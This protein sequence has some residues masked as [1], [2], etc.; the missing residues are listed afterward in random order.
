[1]LN[2]CHADRKKGASA[3]YLLLAI[4]IF[5]GCVSIPSDIEPVQGFELERYLG[6]WYEIARLDHRFERGL[7]NVTAE[8]SIREDGRVRVSIR[9]TGAGIPEDALEHLFVP[10]APQLGE[11]G[12][13]VR[14]VLVERANRH[15]GLSSNAIRRA[16]FR[17]PP[18]DLTARL[19]RLKPPILTDTYAPVERLLFAVTPDQ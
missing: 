13:F 17:W 5:S 4:L 9:D 6:Q 8:Y 2:I 19:E 1:M 3:G 16:W 11:D 10:L 14:E 15:A 18:D 12:V 7:V